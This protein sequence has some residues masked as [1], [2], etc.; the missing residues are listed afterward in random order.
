[1]K[2]VSEVTT[3]GLEWVERRLVEPMVASASVQ[4]MAS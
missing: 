1:V 3:T 2:G 4:D